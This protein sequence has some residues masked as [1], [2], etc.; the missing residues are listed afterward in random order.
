MP[1][2]KWKSFSGKPSQTVCP[3]CAKNLK[4]Y[5]KPSACT[6]CTLTAAFK[7]DK[8]KRFVGSQHFFFFT[9]LA[10]FLRLL[11]SHAKCR[12]DDYPFIGYMRCEAENEKCLRKTVFFCLLWLHYNFS[13][14]RPSFDER[15]LPIARVNEF[16]RSCD[17]R[18]FMGTSWRDIWS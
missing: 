16:S 15:A 18:N 2:K 3:S 4:I 8:C 11:N 17:Q 10:F 1:K 9:D 7:G 13:L 14:P 12:H 6:L 5:G